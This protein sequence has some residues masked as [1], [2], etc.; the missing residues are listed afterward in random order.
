ME[1]G[2]IGDSQAATVKPSDP[3]I[4]QDEAFSGDVHVESFLAAMDETAPV[5]GE[6]IGLLEVDPASFLYDFDSSWSSI[7][8]VQS[9]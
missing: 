3:L 6:E 1:Q 5:P 8:N 7:A 2:V 9:L 4:S